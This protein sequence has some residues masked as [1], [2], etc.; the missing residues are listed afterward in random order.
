M[1]KRKMTENP[2]EK[3]RIRSFRHYRHSH[4]FAD[5]DGSNRDSG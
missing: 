3:P 4:R 2:G 1:R 5:L